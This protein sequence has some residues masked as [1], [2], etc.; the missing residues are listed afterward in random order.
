MVTCTGGTATFATA[1]V[2]TGKT[3][4][5]NGLT[6]SGAQAGNYSAV[7]H[8]G[9]TT[10]ANITAATRDAERHGGQQ[11]VRRHDERGDHA[12]R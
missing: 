5:A 10:T 7:E 6:L 12:A 2:G 9:A 4:T 3:V 1:A 11:D 8:D